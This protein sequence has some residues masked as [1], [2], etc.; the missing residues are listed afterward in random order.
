MDE[1]NKLKGIQKVFGEAGKKAREGDSKATP[2][3][4][5]YQQS[6]QN[7]A[8]SPITL[9]QFSLEEFPFIAQWGLF[10]SYFPFS[11]K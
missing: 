9:I 5:K 3:H 6:L 4:L 7:I 10:T 8:L 11:S 2:E 1:V